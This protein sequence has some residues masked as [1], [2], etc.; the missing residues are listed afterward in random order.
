MP[1]LHKKYI[2]GTIEKAIVVD[3]YILL[4]HLSKASQAGADIQTQKVYI[5]TRAVKHL[6]DKKPAEEYFFLIENLYKLVKVPDRIYE[7][8]NS[9]RGSFCLVKHI[10]GNYYLCSI[11]TTRR[12]TEMGEE[13][14]ENYVATAFRVREENYLKNYKLLWSWKDG[15]P[16]S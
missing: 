8:K 10:K 13:I 3:T 5:T 14:E 2:E 7:N 6:Y 16:S 1:D 11:E 12:V 4:C 15:N 9:K